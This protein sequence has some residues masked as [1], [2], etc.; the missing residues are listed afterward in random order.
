VVPDHTITTVLGTVVKF[1]L[2]SQSPPIV[3]KEI[4]VHAIQNENEMNTTAEHYVA[5]HTHD[6]SNISSV[7][8]S[9]KSL[10]QDSQYTLRLAFHFMNRFSIAH[11]IDSE[12][13]TKKQFPE[14]ALQSI[15]AQMLKGLWYLNKQKHTIHRNIKPSNVLLNSDGLLQIADFGLCASS[16]TTYGVNRDCVGQTMYFSPER[17]NSS[18]FRCAP[19]TS[20]AVVDPPTHNSECQGQ[21]GRLGFGHG[22]PNPYHHSLHFTWISCVQVLFECWIGRYPFLQ[23]GQQPCDLDE[24][25]V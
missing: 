16:V 25:E 6:D 12:T 24:D 10:F 19:C 18:H 8:A 4:V 14:A 23:P 5:S 17:V 1:Y 22:A 7:I 20:V 2:S 15:A 3:V 9:E 21:R 11:V 13:F